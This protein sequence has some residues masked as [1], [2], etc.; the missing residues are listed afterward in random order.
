MNGG[1]L[2]ASRPLLY[3]AI[4]VFNILCQGT[5]CN[6]PWVEVLWVG[7]LHAQSSDPMDQRRIDSNMPIEP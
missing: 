2:V 7:S 1:Y 4:D 3:I 6:L 5:I